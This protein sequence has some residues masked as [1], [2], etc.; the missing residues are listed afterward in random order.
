MK[1]KKEYILLAAVIIGLAAYL[2]FQKTDR[3]HYQLPVPPEIPKDEVSK[4]EIKT[5]DRTVE[6]RKKNGGWVIGAN[7]YPADADSIKEMLETIA[8]LKLTALISES[9][10]YV[11]YDLNEAKN[12]SVK[13]WDGNTLKRSFDIGKT[14][15]TYQHTFVKLGDDP[16]VY[17]ARGYF[18]TKFDKSVDDL[19]DRQV[20]SFEKVEIKEVEIVSDKEKYVM[21]LKPVSEDKTDEKDKAGKTNSS[22]SGG[23]VQKGVWQTTLGKPVDS[24]KLNNLLSTLSDLECD[25]YIEDRKK[26]DFKDPIF[27]VALKGTKEYA[28]SVF[29]KLK[30]DATDYP[31]VSS[32]NPY[33][34]L[35]S[36]NRVDYF[37]RTVEAEKEEEK[38]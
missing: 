32:E 3:S 27:S 38:K 13:A 2:I 35:L 6:I 36:Q 26:E 23:L 1:L 28:L 24:Q 21:S 5:A 17:H 11:R 8:A 29:P 9:K 25:G 4:I 34:F 37:K 15:P 20:L 12:I 18:R 33:V 7:E 19:R 14:A 31:A 30:E 16:N 22:D 10:N